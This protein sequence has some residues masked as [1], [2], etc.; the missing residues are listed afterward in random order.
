MIQ[1]TTKI[2]DRCKDVVAIK[3]ILYHTVKN[4]VTI[5]AD[6]V[7]TYCNMEDNTTA[8]KLHYCRD[9]WNNMLTTIRW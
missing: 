5:R 9:C 7:P 3:G 6:D 4:Y 1:R 2:C 8:Y